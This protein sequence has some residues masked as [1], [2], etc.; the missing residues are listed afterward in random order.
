VRLNTALAL[1]PA[2]ILIRLACAVATAQEAGADVNV[3]RIAVK[4]AAMNGKYNAPVTIEPACKI[5]E[6]PVKTIYIAE[7]REA[8]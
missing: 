5:R 3:N 2:Q 7:I 4:R 1:A 8:G 6:V